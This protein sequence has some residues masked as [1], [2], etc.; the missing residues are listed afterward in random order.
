MGLDMFAFTTS[1]PID[2]VKD[3]FD[4]SQCQELH[5]WR[6][7]PDLHGWMEELYRHRHGR[8]PEFNYLPVV[9]D[10][11]DLA[12]LERDIKRRALP[13]TVGF[14]FGESNGKEQDYDLIFVAKARRALAE[15]KTVFYLSWW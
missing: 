2:S 10:Y 9:L 12:K 1:R 4:Q 5:Y 7:H 6:K 14:F 8:P 3:Y 13:K 15:G 11:D